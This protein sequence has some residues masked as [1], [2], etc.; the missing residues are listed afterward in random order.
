MAAVVPPRAL[1]TKS[2]FFRLRTTRFISLSL[3]LLS[4]GTAPSVKKTFSSF[5]WLRA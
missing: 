4:M 3:T 2:E 5:H 1:P